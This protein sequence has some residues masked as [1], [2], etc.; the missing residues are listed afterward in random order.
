MLKRYC[1]SHFLS[2]RV[3]SVF[4]P[5]LCQAGT[6]FNCHPFGLPGEFYVVLRHGRRPWD[7][8]R[9]LP[10]VISQMSLVPCPC[11]FPKLWL[12]RLPP[13]PI[14]HRAGKSARVI[15]SEPKDQPIPLSLQVSTV[16]PIGLL[17]SGTWFPIQTLQTS[18]F[19]LSPG[20]G[21]GC[22]FSGNTLLLSCS[23]TPDH[24]LNK[25]PS[26][27]HTTRPILE[28]Q[29]TSVSAPLKSLAPGIIV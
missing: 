24:G 23:K 20:E 12:F 18:L 7:F 22:P 6:K 9:W 3:I 16:S 21:W 15:E 8:G 1:V 28:L 19:L 13:H 5:L 17:K 29:T 2:L 27:L 4:K 14:P 25:V 26:V 11:C 10:Y